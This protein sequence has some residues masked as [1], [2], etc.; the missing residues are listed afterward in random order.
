MIL[1]TEPETLTVW[2]ILGQIGFSLSI[3]ATKLSLLSLYHRL[4]PLPWMRR[5]LIFVALFV[6][7]YTVANVFAEIFQ[8]IPMRA[9]W[10]STVNGTC[11][12]SSARDMS[13]TIINLT[14]DIVVL[15][16]PMRPVWSLQVSTSKKWQL[17]AMFSLGGLVCVIS[18]VRVF[19]TMKFY[20]ADPT[21]ESV[22]GAELALLECCGGIIAACLPACRPL[23]RL[24]T[25][26]ENL[27]PRWI[28]SL[29]RISQT[30][31]YSMPARSDSTVPMPGV[32]VDKSLYGSVN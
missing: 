26:R 10:D 19:Y 32:G 21:W 24:N 29:R 11:M 28:P 3:L 17:S 30:D 7:G 13:T 27:H 16:L 5:L 20:S 22:E 1:V 2:L 14:T 9:L 15:I 18:L 8:C 12:N 25:K 31:C 23:L 6:T 4:F